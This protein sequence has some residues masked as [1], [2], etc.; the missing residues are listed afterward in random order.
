MQSLIKIVLIFNLIKTNKKNVFK[1]LNAIKKFV[2]KT[3]IKIVKQY[4]LFT[5]L[6]FIYFE[7]F[8]LIENTL[9]HIKS[10]IYRVTVGSGFNPIGLA[11]PT[12]TLGPG[13]SSS[14]T[15]W[16]GRRM[17]AECLTRPARS[18]DVT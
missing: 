4:L 11:R 16:G 6:N 12:L 3:I 17:R 8:F 15:R 7:N 14:P 5:F 1:L 13:K 10:Y 9:S 18:R 2:D